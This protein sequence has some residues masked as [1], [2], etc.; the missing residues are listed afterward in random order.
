MRC[1]EWLSPA[2]A[3]LCRL[4]AA[5]PQPCRTGRT[6]FFADKPALSVAKSKSKNYIKPGVLIRVLN[7]IVLP[8]DCFEGK[9]S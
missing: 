1:S 9:N 2:T 3:G 7:I 5:E 8:G 6:D 4:Y